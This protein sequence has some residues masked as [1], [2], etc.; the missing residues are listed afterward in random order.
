MVDA[1][2]SMPLAVYLP[3]KTKADKKYMINLNGYRNWSFIESNQV[4]KAYAQIAKPKIEGLQF[5]LPIKLTFTLW[6]RDKRLIDRANPL[7]IH[8]KFWCDALTQFGAITD[9]N[10]K[11]IHSTRYYTGGI[12]RE[13]PRVDIMMQEIEV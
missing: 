8:E 9:D 6:K 1:T 13:N 12:D 11:Y 7:C 3:R 2:V 5:G 10:D 4:K